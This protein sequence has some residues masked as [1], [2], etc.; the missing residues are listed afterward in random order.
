MQLAL[1]PDNRQLA[2]QR[3]QGPASDLW[4]FDVARGVGSKLTVDGNNNGPVWS[5]DGRELAYRS[6]RRVLNEVFRLSLATNTVAPWDGVP[7]ERLEDWSRDGRYLVLGRAA[8]GVPIAV[9]LTGNRTPIPV[10]AVPP[11]GVADEA[12][13]SPDSRWLSYNLADRSGRP[14]IYVQPFPGPGQR[15]IASVG[16]GVQAKW[17]PDGRELFYLSPDGILMAVDVRPG[18]PLVLGT[19]RP[20]FKTGIASP[21]NNVDQY[22]R[23]ARWPAVPDPRTDAVGRA[24]VADDHHELDQPAEE[25]ATH[26]ATWRRG[27]ASRP[28]RSRPGARCRVRLLL[29]LELYPDLEADDVH[30]ALLFA[31][32]AV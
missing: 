29:D 14:V 17:R 16:G 32:A 18:D 27:E 7:P 2:A 30:E 9:P 1:A 26:G 23:H 13:F 5:P 11:A 21:A 19:S 12:Q 31:A 24:A 28:P 3:D 15:T 8:D 25:V 22:V 20:L 6:N 4:L 10:A